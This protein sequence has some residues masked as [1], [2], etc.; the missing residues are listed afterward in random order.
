MSSLCRDTI[1][2]SE[3]E[4]ELL[5]LHD[6]ERLLARVTLGTANPQR[7]VQQWVLPSCIYRH[8]GNWASRLNSSRVTALLGQ[9]D[10]LEDVCQQI[11]KTI[12]EEPP[13]QLNDGGVI[14]RGYDE[15]LDQL[16]D[17]SGN[18]RTVIAQLERNE[19]RNTG[20]ESLK[21]SLQLDLWLLH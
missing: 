18:S 13:I 21:G 9:M 10:S 2:R 19:R 3:L 12:A 4:R 8:Y 11:T 1:V 6:I 7:P 5:Y 20:I 15:E 16:R 17:I 14:A